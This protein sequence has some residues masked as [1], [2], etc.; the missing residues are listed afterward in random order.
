MKNVKPKD[1][2]DITFKEDQLISLGKLNGALVSFIS[3]YHG[4]EWGKVWFSGELITIMKDR[5]SGI[6]LVTSPSPETKEETTAE[7]GLLCDIRD[8]L[9]KITEALGLI[10]TELPLE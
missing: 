8:E 5:I 1:V 9:V 4:K 3:P 7:I 6:E 2:V 10:Y